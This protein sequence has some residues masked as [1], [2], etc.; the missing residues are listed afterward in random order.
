MSF[1]FNQ[2]HPTWPSYNTIP[3]ISNRKVVI[4]SR[5]QASE[6][7]KHYTPWN[8]PINSV[9]V[10]CACLRIR[11]MPYMMLSPVLL[12]TNKISGRSQIRPLSQTIAVASNLLQC[13]WV[14]C[15]QSSLTPV[16]IFRLI[17]AIPLFLVYHVAKCTQTFLTIFFHILSS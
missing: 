7:T 13:C 2:S 1:S 16:K 6:L 12:C 8:Q 4:V 14:L 15:S 10:I 11:R 3:K 9:I 17:Q 5:Y